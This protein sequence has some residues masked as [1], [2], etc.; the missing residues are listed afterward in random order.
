VSA[1]C[2]PSGA[3]KVSYNP[4]TRKLQI[5][6]TGASSSSVWDVSNSYFI[7]FQVPGPRQGIRPDNVSD[8]GYFSDS[9]EILGTKPTKDG[10]SGNYVQAFQSTGIGNTTFTSFYPASLYTIESL[11][12]QSNLQTNN[13]QSP[14]LDADSQA[15]R[16]IP[17]QV[18]AR[19]P[20]DMA[21]LFQGSKQ[22]VPSIIQFEDTGAELFSMTLQS[23]QLDALNF[24]IVDA[25]GREIEQVADDQYANG[26][27][28]YKMVLRWEAIEDEYAGKPAGR[29]S[30]MREPAMYQRNEY[31]RSAF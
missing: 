7:T 5:D 16:L 4:N 18:F 26:A 6:M 10:G 14:S 3:D 25:K 9:Y 30:Q 17:T 27:L 23:K 1:D 22:D 8:E 13:Y 12:L 11:H 15:S 24:T 29:L 31:I 19:I 2:D 21:K 28:A 20:I